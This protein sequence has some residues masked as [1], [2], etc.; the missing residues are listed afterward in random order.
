MHTLYPETSSK[1]C[2]NL[3]ILSLKNSAALCH[4]GTCPQVAGIS[5]I[6]W[7]IYIYRLI[8]LSQRWVLAVSL[9]YSIIFHILTTFIMTL[10]VWVYC[11]PKYRRSTDRKF[12][13]WQIKS[14]CTSELSFHGLHQTDV[15]NVQLID[16]HTVFYIHI[17]YRHW[18]IYRHDWI[19]CYCLWYFLVPSIPLYPLCIPII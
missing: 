5:H 7:Y 3:Y 1:W 16:W 9:T 2:Y 12:W 4:V 13:A 11:V 19:S 14:R 10:T 8:H 18:D 17:L 15:T 6:D